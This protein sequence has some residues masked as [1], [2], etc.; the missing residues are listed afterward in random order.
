VDDS[1]AAAGTSGRD[2]LHKADIRADGGKRRLA[3]LRD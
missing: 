3:Y 2:A 1:E